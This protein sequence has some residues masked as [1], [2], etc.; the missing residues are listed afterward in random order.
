MTSLPTPISNPDLGQEELFQL[1]VQI[2]ASNL[3]FN[4]ILLWVID[5]DHRQL[6]KK[7][8]LIG[9]QQLI[10]GFIKISIRQSFETI[11]IS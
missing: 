5:Y 6:I 2:W 7:A 11:T 8:I 10:K 1:Q 3:L 9:D 4:Q